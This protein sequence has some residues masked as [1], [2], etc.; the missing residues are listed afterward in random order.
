MTRRVWFFLAALALG[1]VAALEAASLF[2]F[3]QTQTRLPQWDMAGHGWGGVELLQALAEGD[4]LAFLG[5]L[6]RQDKW[7]FGYSL[8][9]LPFLAL[10]KASFA[11]AT[12][13]QTVLFAATPLLLLWTVREV[14]RGPGGLWAGALA[15]VLFLASPLHRVFAVLVMRETAGVA[16]TLLALVLY[17]R[18]RR[19]G[20]PACWRWA[21]AALL[22][23]FLVKYN[24]A[25]VLWAALA[26]DEVLRLGRDGRRRLWWT[27]KSILWPW[28]ARRPGSVTLAVYLYALA[29]SAAAGINPGVGIY[30]G[31]VVGTVLLA[32]AW[33]RRQPALLAWWAS[34]PVRGRA[35]L[36]T[37]VAPLWIWCL[38]PSPIHP[39]SIAA[40]LRNRAT[41]PELGSLDALLDYPRSL[42]ADY[43]PHPAVGAV[44]LGALGVSLL[45][46]RRADA[47]FRTLA[48]AGF[49]GLALATLHPYKEPRFLATTVP[50]LMLLAS[51][52]VVG[53]AA[54][55]KRWA[56]AALGAAAIAGVA[57]LGWL[58][59][60]RGQRVAR[61]YRLYSASSALARPLAFLV[62]HSAGKQRVAVA[63]T[64][65]ELSD[66]LIRWSLYGNE[67]TRSA[68][69]VKPL[70]RPDKDSD[71]ASRVDAWLERERPDVV[72]A[73]CLLPESPRYRSPDFVRY[74]RW[75]LAVVEKLVQD[76]R[77]QTVRRRTFRG[78][79]I[80]ITTLAPRTAPAV[81]RSA[82]PRSDR[83]G[84]RA[85]PARG[86]RTVPPRQRNRSQSR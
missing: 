36:Q 71:P 55:W 31:L 17:L 41:G 35:L 75:Q 42:I 1:L 64:F 86:R 76:P 24:Y 27:V 16:F 74:N 81:T 28:P 32:V 63:G 49:L 9:L 78:V 56:G 54:R 10:G 43:A 52:S 77:F 39:K 14:D 85:G 3:Y 51:L 2:G 30:A 37:V 67:T 66:N 7:P 20:T 73:V 69:L 6:N 25:A 38:S 50:L 70:T 60:D 18:A 33:S 72:H 12:L 19:L 46:L 61:D 26:V 58:G 53:L 8:L 68:R 83:A 21:G 47:H 79:E 22:A 29:L 40:F 11:S 4:P 45:L 48:L 34:L 62:R 23:L 80:E 65:N 15:G 44:L 13:L 57:W 59:T 5:R 82:G 84:P